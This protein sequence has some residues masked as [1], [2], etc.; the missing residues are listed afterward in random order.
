[1]ISVFALLQN[2]GPQSTVSLYFEA[3][4]KSDSAAEGRLLLQDVRNDS[5]D[6]LRS[7]LNTLRADNTTPP[8]IE[9]K[10]AFVLGRQAVVDAEF[11]G[12]GYG[13]FV[14]RMILVKPLLRWKVDAK[15]SWDYLNQTQSSE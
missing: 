7:A 10:R 5:A 15:A 1:M 14:L 8:K 3:V 12:T 2:Q 9:I 4:R 11:V 13:H 6:K